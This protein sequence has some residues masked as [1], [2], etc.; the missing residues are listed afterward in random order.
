M[1]TKNWKFTRGDTSVREVQLSGALGVPLTPE[2]QAALLA[3]SWTAQIRKKA[4]DAV[5]IGDIRIE[6]EL[7]VV[8]LCIDTE[9]S[10]RL[11]GTCVTDLQV[12]WIGSDGRIKRLTVI[13][14]EIE[15][16]ADVTR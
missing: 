14:Y 16:D 12:E 1:Q 7:G 10:E 9:L 13:R 5:E 3:A 6:K 11:P 15:T 2:Q 4:S 8:R